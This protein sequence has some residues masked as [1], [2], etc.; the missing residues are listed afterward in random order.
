MAGTRKRIK[1][2]IQRTDDGYIGYPVGLK[3]AVVGEGDTY[4]EALRDVISA[5]QAHVETFGPEVLADATE[6][7]DVFVAE[8]EVA[9]A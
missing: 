9:V 8:T 5:V 3:G 1:L 4:E 6:A 2:I 7:D